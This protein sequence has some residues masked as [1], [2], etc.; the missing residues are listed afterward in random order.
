MNIESYLQ[1][2]V[3]TFYK[4]MKDNLVGIYLH[5]SLAMECFNPNRSDID[6]L[7]VVKNKLS[8]DEQQ[9]ITKHVLLLHDEVPSGR[10]L[11]FSVVLESFVTQFVYPT[12]TEYHYSVHHREKYQSDENYVLGGFEDPDLAAHFTVTIHRG[13]ALYGKPILTLFQPIERT[14]YAQSILNDIASAPTEIIDAPVYYVLNLCRVLQ[15]LQEGAVASK[16]EG[17]EWAINVL[18][19]KFNAIVSICLDEYSGQVNGPEF[20]SVLLVEFAEYM[21]NEIRKLNSDQ[22]I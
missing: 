22:G 20:D 5:G 7:I 12:P 6:L 14:Y 17:G 10:G 15:F 9:A 16:Q 2:N 11:E 21:L 19:S 8:V 1:K 13:I 18:P 4:V 3:A